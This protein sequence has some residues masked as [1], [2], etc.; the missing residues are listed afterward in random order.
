MS[1]SSLNPQMF[2]GSHSFAIEGG[3]FNNIGISVEES[4]KGLLELFRHSS[5]SALFNAEAR[6]PPPKCHPGTRESILKDLQSWVHSDPYSPNSVRWLYGPAGAGKSAI[7]QTLAESFARDESLAAAFFFWRSDDS[8]NN[9]HKLF[10]TI[11][12][13]LAA[14]IPELRSIINQAVLRNLSALTSSI[15]TQFDELVLKPCLEAIRA[16]NSSLSLRARILI[17]DGLDEC[18]D[19]RTQQRILSILAPAMQKCTLPFRILIASRPEPR[20]KE[21]FSS[22]HLE[23]ICSWISLSNTYQASIDIRKFLQDRFHEILNHH[24]STMKHITCPWP[25]SSQIE[26]LVSKASGHFA[27]ASTVLKYIDDDSAVP[28]DRLDIVLGL[29]QEEIEGEETT[30]PFAELDALYHQILSTNKNTALIVRILGILISIGDMIFYST[31]EKLDVLSI[32]GIPSQKV[33]AALSAAHSLFKDP[34]PIE[35]GLNFAHAS[36]QD[37]L[38]DPNRSLHFYINKPYWHSYIAQCYLDIIVEAQYQPLT[39]KPMNRVSGRLVYQRRD[40][41]WTI[42][43]NCWLHHCM[44]ANCSDK[45]LSKLQS[46]NVYAATTLVLQEVLDGKQG[47][48]HAKWD[49]SHLMV[50][51]VMLRDYFFLK[52]NHEPGTQIN[53][54]MKN[55]WDITTIGFCMEFLDNEGKN[56]A[57]DIP[58]PGPFPRIDDQFHD[59]MQTMIDDRLSLIRNR[60]FTSMKV[61]PLETGSLRTT[62]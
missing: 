47:E 15:E 16:P 41:K 58:V 48:E 8:R 29:Q 12:L 23:G 3:T 7:A 18:S 27:Y 22:S 32:L 9:A 37:F 6:F 20:I 31:R 21:A 17:I 10:T 44:Q 54:H 26:I 62:V 2:A 34:S 57:F 51:F 60:S 28:E 40:D 49:F 35:S 14:T 39:T 36:F 13:Q 53:W 11:S 45:L 43:C 30:S 33:Q 55:F 1:R 61:T 24:L 42:V 5:S 56:S 38:F 25:S 46:F 50:D 4:E 59:T 19:S 52:G